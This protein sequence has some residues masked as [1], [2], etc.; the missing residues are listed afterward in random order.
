MKTTAQFN[1]YQKG[2]HRSRSPLAS[3]SPSIPDAQR[4]VDEVSK[5]FG[6]PN[7]GERVMAE[8]IERG[9]RLRGVKGEGNV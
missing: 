6:S 7:L 3:P 1:A 2:R 5:L 9:N 4:S 8:N